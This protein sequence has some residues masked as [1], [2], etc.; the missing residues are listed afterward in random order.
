MNTK[1]KICGITRE[2]DAY[3]AVEAGADALGFVFYRPSSRYIDAERAQEIINTLP[4]FVAAVGV[5]VNQSTEQ[6]QSLLKKVSLNLLQLHGEESPQLCSSYGIPYIKALRVRSI[7]QA[8]TLAS[9]FPDT[10]A[11]LLDT[12]KSD[13]YGGTGESFFWQRLP[14]SIV[15][16]VILAG[17]LDADNVGEAIR[18]VQPYAVDVSS[19][20]EHEKGKKDAAEISRFIS[21]V[22]AVDVKE[23]KK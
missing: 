4:P 19:G 12:L 5:L 2:E 16:P 9:N 21:A 7:E 11:L 20:V 23:T 6:V 18:T 15:K 3:A 8:S 13:I 1:V 14:D 10:R 22:N 17:G